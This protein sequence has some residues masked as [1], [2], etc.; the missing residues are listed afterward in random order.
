MAN[1]T[2]NFTAGRMNK[3]VDERLIP[4]GEYIDALNIRMGSTEQSEIGAIENTK[5]NLPL[6]SLNYIDGTPLSASARCI[7]AIEDAANETIYWFVHDPAFPVGATGK[8]D[9]I[10]SFN[11]FTNILTYNVISIDDG[12]GLNTTLNFNPTYLITGVNIINDFLYFTDNYNPPRF[13]NTKI[14]YPNPVLDIDQF[15]AESILVIKQPPIEAPTIQP[16]ATSSQDNFLETRFICF[17]YRYEYADGQ[18]SATSQFSAPSFFPKPFNFS[19]ESYLNEG[20]V[21]NTNACNIT[22]NTGGPLVKSIDLLFKNA[23]GN[24]IKVIEKLN[25]QE[26]GIPDNSLYPY[27]FS[28]SKIFTVLPESELL[29]LYDNVPLLAQAQTIMGNR[30]M[31]GNYIEGYDLVDLNGIATMF[32]YTTTLVSETI[33]DTPIPD[34]TAIGNYTINGPISVTDAYVTMDLDGLN[35]ISGSVINL[36]VNI[37]HAQFS[38]T[39]PYPTATTGTI[40]LSFTFYLQ[41]NYASVYDLANSTE[42]KDAIGTTLNIKPVYSAN[43][44]DETSCDGITFTDNVNCVLPN[45]LGALTKYRSGITGTNQPIFID[46]IPGSPIIG[47]LFPAMEYVN[48]VTTPTQSVFE[49]YKVNFAQATFQEIANPKS[50]H[51]NRDYEIG[52]VYMD[53][54]NRSSTALVSPLNTQHIPCGYAKNK[55]SIRVTIPT[56]QIAP[57]WATRYK[58]VIKPDEENY[59]TIYSSIFFKDPNTNETYFLLEGENARKV[60]QGDRYIVKADSDGPTETCV[61]ATVLEK[62]SKAENFIIIPSEL[63]PSQDIYV[64]SGVYMKINTNSFSAVTDELAVIAPGN[65]LTTAEYTGTSPILNY[66]MNVERVVGYDPLNPTWVYQDYTVPAGSRIKLLI[67]LSRLGKG[68]GTGLCE[69]RIYT[70]EKTYVSSNNYDNMQDWWN[71]ENIQTTINDGITECG[72]GCTINNVYIPTTATTAIDVLTALGT[73]YYKFYRN[74]T[75]NYLGLLVTGTETCG[76]SRAGRLSKASADITV[77]RAETT[78]VFETEPQ[79]AQPNIWYE[80]DLS[81][82]ISASG[83]HMGNVTDQDFALGIPAVI[84]TNFFNCFAFGN[85]VESYKI[86]DSIT[87]RAFNL[88]NRVTSV[89]N[90]DYSEVNRFADITYSGVF[91]NESNVNK[92]NEFNLGLLNFKNLEISFGPIYLMDA[93]KTDILVL[94]EDKISYVLEGKNMLYDATGGSVLTSVPEILGSQVARTEKYGISFNPESY[95]QWGTDRYFTDTKRGAVIQLTG[96]DSASSQLTVVSESGMRSWFRD[97][98]IESFNT[99]KL[100]G[101]DPYL[102]EYV[103]SSNDIV[104]P[105]NPQCL[106]CGITQTFVLTIGDEINYCVDLSQLVGDVIISY[107]IVGVGTVTINANYNDIIY[108]SGDIGG[109]GSF[110]FNK[111]IQNISTVDIEIISSGNVTL[112][113]TVNCPAQQELKIVNVVITND[114]QAGETIHTQYRYTNGTFVSPLQSNLVSFVSGTANPL[115][116]YYNILTGY[117][118]SGGF[119]PAGSTMT[120]STNKYASDTFDFDPINDKFMYYRSDTLYANNPVDIQALLTAA[121]IA[122]PNLGGGAYNYA[123]FTVPTTGEYLYLIWNF[124][125]SVSVPLCYDENDNITTICCDCELPCRTFI[126]ENLETPSAEFQWIDCNGDSQ[127]VIITTATPLPY[128]TICVLKPYTPFLISG[129]IGFDLLGDCSL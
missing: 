99:Q 117:V 27:Q 81:F 114:Y 109:S 39:L 24:I 55:N 23:D 103:L 50:L 44:L 20:M 4:N 37:E 62:E 128:N 56:T 21:N 97:L 2:R 65:L 120:I 54:F 110:N 107:S 16:I 42:F 124:R 92:L 69:R 28:N 71:G 87:G 47:L 64:P 53:E 40:Q 1:I 122:S 31:Y 112:Q 94:Q 76:G 113:L 68:D 17:A 85:G 12:N 30:L 104:V 14:N 49:Y 43:P 51:S 106:D 66:P 48:N 126:P 70:L 125:D 8:L 102:N 101:F 111:D 45:T 116:S 96:D 129:I 98:F 115:V 32:E 84:D 7:G 121:S 88:G 36:D 41:T 90:Q 79:D 78:I 74:A 105:S 25:K 61:Y 123:D 6:T 119:P 83:E 5:G 127:N 95:V 57:Y 72:G 38:G 13:I 100:G 73:N 118:G 33:G 58:F 82:S 9:I 11:V 59:E 19:I 34:G 3:V 108:S 60:E 80:N 26:L 67:K 18:Y 35:L 29:R 77:Y 75:T 89:A 91:N 10:A 52:I 63:D 46:T 93:R 22:L 15:S 86:R